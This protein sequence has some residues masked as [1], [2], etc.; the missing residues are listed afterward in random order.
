MASHPSSSASQQGAAERQRH[1]VR[2]PGP[3]VSAHPHFP[4]NN[5]TTC[6]EKWRQK[7]RSS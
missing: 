7:K 1:D 6:I 2:A 3:R 4:S 5:N